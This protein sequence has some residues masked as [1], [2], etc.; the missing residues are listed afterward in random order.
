MV[1][2]FHGSLISR[3]LQILNRSRNLFQRNFDDYGLVYEQRARLQISQ[4]VVLCCLIREDSGC[5]PTLLLRETHTDSTVCGLLHPFS[6]L[7][8]PGTHSMR[9]YR[10]GWLWEYQW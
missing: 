5:S 4:R 10:E 9:R 3:I 6:L 7:S 1:L 2:I 8:M